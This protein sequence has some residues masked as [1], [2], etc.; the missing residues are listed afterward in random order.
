VAKTD[1]LDLGPGRQEL[2]DELAGIVAD[3]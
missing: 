3:E 2:L 1:S